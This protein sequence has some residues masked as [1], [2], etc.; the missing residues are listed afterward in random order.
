MLAA[1]FPLSS[2]AETSNPALVQVS[3]KN[4]NLHKQTHK[5]HTAPKHHSSKPKHNHAHGTS[6]T[7]A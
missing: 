2:I 3:A 5:K 6:H 4:K 1:L 7:A